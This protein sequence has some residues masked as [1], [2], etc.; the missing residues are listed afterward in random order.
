MNIFRE[1]DTEEIKE[2]KLWARENYVPGTKVNEVY[3]PVVQQECDLI[4]REIAENKQSNIFYIQIKQIKPRNYEN[5]FMQGR[6][7]SFY[8]RSNQS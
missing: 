3:H 1:L 4:N 6:N 5:V 7:R 8:N 2:F